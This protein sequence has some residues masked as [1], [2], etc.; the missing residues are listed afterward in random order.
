MLVVVVAVDIQ[1]LPY[2]VL[3]EPVGVVMEPTL[4]LVL[5]VLEQQTL[6]A[7]VAAALVMLVMVAQAAQVLSLLSSTNR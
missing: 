5:E 6:V 3:V 1:D 2:E 4:M 7:V